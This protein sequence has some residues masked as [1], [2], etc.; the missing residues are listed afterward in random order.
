MSDYSPLIDGARGCKFYLCFVTRGVGEVDNTIFSKS[1]N[2]GS[3]D[4]TAPNAQGIAY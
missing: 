3:D 1:S 4:V 2:N